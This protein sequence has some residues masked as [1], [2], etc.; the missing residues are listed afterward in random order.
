LRVAVFARGLAARDD[1]GDRPG[2]CRELEKAEAARQP[3]EVTHRGGGAEGNDDE[4]RSAHELVDVRL[5]SDLRS[6]ILLSTCHAG[7]GEKKSDRS[8]QA[9]SAKRRP[10]AESQDRVTSCG[11]EQVPRVASSRNDC[12]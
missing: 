9:A 12:S 6:P 3:E 7:D 2:G 5:E 4:A 10:P 8:M 11:F 1:G